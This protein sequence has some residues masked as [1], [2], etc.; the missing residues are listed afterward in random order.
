L[1]AVAHQ[2]KGKSL[3]VAFQELSS[4]LSEAKRHIYSMQGEVV[5]ALLGSR[6][7]EFARGSM[8][9]TDIYFGESQFAGVERVKVED[10]PAWGMGYSGGV[11]PQIELGTEISEIISFLC[12]ALC[13]GNAV[14]PIRGPSLHSSSKYRYTINIVGDISAFQAYEVIERGE[15]QVWSYN[16]SGGVLRA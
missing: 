3:R 14:V 15:Q 8:N 12:E 5:A 7:Y 9:Y 16:C 6:Q 10:I 4:F 2:I 11:V 13:L 1:Q